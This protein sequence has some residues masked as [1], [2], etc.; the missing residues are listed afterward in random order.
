[1]CVILISDERRMS[2]ALIASAVDANPDGNGFAWIDRGVVRFE[3][4]ITVDRA[5]ELAATVALPYIFH[6]RIATIG[7]VGPDLCHPFPFD[8]RG[9]RRRGTTTAGVLFHNGT[10]SAWEEW[11]DREAGPWSDSLAMARHLA[12]F[13]DEYFDRIVP[14]TQRVALIRPSGITVSGLGWSHVRPGIRAS[15][16][17][18]D[19]ERPVFV[20]AGKGATNVSK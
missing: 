18:F 20:R 16:R 14:S 5:Q 19:R 1:M 17:Y 13:G 4:A 12:T 6:A 8:R 11:I 3:K 10:W 2:D 7:A 15:N 9:N